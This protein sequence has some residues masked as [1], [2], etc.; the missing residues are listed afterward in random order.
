MTKLS[1]VNNSYI[2]Y[3]LKPFLYLL[4]IFRKP[5]IMKYL[6]FTFAFTIFTI[7]SFSQNK[8]L[9]I[10]EHSNE[11]YNVSLNMENFSEIKSVK[12]KG[13]TINSNSDSK[14]ILVSLNKK[15]VSEKILVQ[16][17][18]LTNSKSEFQV[19]II[20]NNGNLITY[21]KVILNINEEMFAEK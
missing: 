10:I 19:E 17:L 2:I 18:D 21:P 15:N 9:F 14:K 4:V 1:T 6:I 8:P 5:D 20:Y 13:R 12:I 7:L 11:G 16:R 3:Y